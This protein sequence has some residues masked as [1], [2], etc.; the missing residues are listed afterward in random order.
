MFILLQNEP[1]AKCRLSNPSI[2]NTMPN[3]KAT[4]S[5]TPFACLPIPCRCICFSA[6][7]PRRLQHA[8]GILHLVIQIPHFASIKKKRP[9]VGWS[10]LFGGDGGIWT[11]ARLSTPSGFRIRTL[12]PLGYISVRLC[13]I[14]SRREKIKA[15]S[16]VPKAGA[17]FPW[18][19]RNFPV[20]GGEGSGSNP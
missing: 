13:I 15:F 14:P 9:P 8:T 16:Q 20:G 1:F 11:P 19:F 6:E 17:F 10:F 5:G 12:Q 2:A 4:L 7:K 3:K 18:L